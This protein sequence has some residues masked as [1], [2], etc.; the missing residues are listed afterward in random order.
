M[1]MSIGL[2]HKECKLQ[3][4]IWQLQYHIL[5]NLLPNYYICSGS[6]F[7]LTGSMKWR[8]WHKMREIWYVNT[9]TSEKYTS[10]SLYLE[11]D[12]AFNPRN[13][14]IRLPDYTAL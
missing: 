14:D 7:R 11:E 10:P 13:V 9:N 12:A 2:M 1:A 6:F 8:Q 4:Y 5:K 3:M